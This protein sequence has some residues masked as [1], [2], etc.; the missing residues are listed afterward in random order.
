MANH[1]CH[2]LDIECQYGSDSLAS[3]DDVDDSNTRFNEIFRRLDRIEGRVFPSDFSPPARNTHEQPI[4]SSVNTDFPN[5]SHKWAIDPGQLKSDY[6]GFI[7]WGSVFRIL[8]ETRTTVEAIYKVYHEHTHPWLPMICSNRF[9]ANYRNFRELKPDLGFLI[10]VLAMHL[11]VTPPS[12]HPAAK[13]LSESPWY[14]ACKHYFMHFV[15]LTKPS[16]DLLQAGILISLFEHTQYVENSA[17]VTLG[18][19]ARLAYELDFDDIVPQ[20]LAK[21]PESRSLE[22]VEV[23]NTWF[24]LVLLDRYAPVPT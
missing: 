14:R 21:D 20:E 9:E 8:N 24:A 7:L 13:S 3:K 16:V 11:I 6:L 17:L 22:A 2:R 15:G 23:M 4:L 1:V 18:V 19:C 10:T 5:D 12:K